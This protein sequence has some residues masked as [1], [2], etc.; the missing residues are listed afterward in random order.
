MCIIFLES[1]SRQLHSV[2]GRREAWARNIWHTNRGV[3]RQVNELVRVSTADMTG[4]FW[5]ESKPVSGGEIAARWIWEGTGKSE[6]HNKCDTQ[7]F[8]S[9][10]P[11]LFIFGG[12]LETITREV[13]IFWNFFFSRIFG[14]CCCLM[15][16][17]CNPWCRVAFDCLRNG[18]KR[19]STAH[20]F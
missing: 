16:R 20:S 14:Q 12:V 18:E 7:D 1:S 17:M 8:V 2:G 19:N 9:S 6:G 11:I 13:D 10:V 5:D 15:G 3:L 4:R